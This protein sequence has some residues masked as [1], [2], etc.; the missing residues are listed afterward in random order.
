M[1]NFLKVMTHTIILVLIYCCT[2]LV[3]SSLLYNSQT[4]LEVTKCVNS[5]YSASYNN[6]RAGVYNRQYS[7]GNALQSRQSVLD[8]VQYQGSAGQFTIVPVSKF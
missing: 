8:V 3:P 7:I 1:P 2:R 4:Y 5:I 6:K